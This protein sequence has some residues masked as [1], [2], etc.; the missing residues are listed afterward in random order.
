MLSSY[1]MLFL[2]PV[3]VTAGQILMK[4]NAG[5]VVTGKGFPAFIKS[6]LCP[7][8][9]GAGICMAAAPL[10]YINALSEIQLSEAFAFNSL[11]Y[12]LVF[13]SAR[14]LLNERINLFQVIG[15]ILITAGFL[16]P[17]IVEAAGA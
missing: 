2:M 17:F 15:V 10:L 7:G 11:N 13:I 8:I 3:L 6:L 12:I 1:F 14:F 9:V 5:A 16:L 4:R